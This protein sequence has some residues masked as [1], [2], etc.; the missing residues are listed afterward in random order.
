MLRSNYLFGD[1]SLTQ[2]NTFLLA[3]FVARLIFYIVFYG[4]FDLDLPMF[5][6]VVGLSVCLNGGVC[7][8]PGVG[9]PPNNESL[10]PA[11]ETTSRLAD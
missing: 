8:R 4:Q 3:Y 11:L 5:A 6:G 9:L 10:Q 2:V 7:R 1:P